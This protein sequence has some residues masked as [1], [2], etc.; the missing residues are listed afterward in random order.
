MND[1]LRLRLERVAQRETMTADGEAAE[2]VF[3]GGEVLR[4]L[5]IRGASA[6]PEDAP[7]EQLDEAE[8]NFRLLLAAAEE[9]AVPRGISRFDDEAVT[10]ALFK[11]CPVHP[12]C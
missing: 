8:H 7:D 2:E 6:L 3:E 11:I 10:A 12:F 5:I 1:R 9:A 4:Q